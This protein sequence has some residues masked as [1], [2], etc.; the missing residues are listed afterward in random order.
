METKQRIN[1]ALENLSGKVDELQVG[2]INSTIYKYCG[3][4]GGWRERR[5]G[6]TREAR[7]LFPISRKMFLGGPARP[8]YYI[9]PH[10][11]KVASDAAL[12]YGAYT[13]VKLLGTQLQK[14]GRITRVRCD[15]KGHF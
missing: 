12:L 1:Q 10:P 7:V 9:A 11:R 6:N 13:P 15:F 2:L 5:P 8:F 3:A 4:Q 14:K